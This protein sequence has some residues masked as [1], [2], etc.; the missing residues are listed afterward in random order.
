[1]TANLIRLNTFLLH[2]PH[3]GPR[4]GEFCS[5]SC[6]PLLSQLAGSIHATWAMPINGE[7]YKPK[8][9]VPP[10]FK[11]VLLK[12]TLQPFL[13]LFTVYPIHFSLV[14]FSSFTMLCFSLSNGDMMKYLP[15]N[16]AMKK[17]ALL[18]Q[19]KPIFVSAGRI[20]R[21]KGCNCDNIAKSFAVGFVNG[22]T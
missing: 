1:M 20:F 8:R 6:L 7:L 9:F 3:T 10:G 19:T 18:V 16:L 2:I 4:F 15:P 17:T 12:S 14:R 22:Y 21:Y 11:K 5:C 13:P